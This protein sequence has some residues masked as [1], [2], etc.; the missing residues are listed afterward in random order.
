MQRQISSKNYFKISTV[1]PAASIAD[2]AFSLIAF[3]L[4]F[5]LVFIS[6]DDIHNLNKFGSPGYKFGGKVSRL[7]IDLCNTTFQYLYNT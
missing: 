7:M 5:I 6:D 3:T 2:F 4:K 1:P